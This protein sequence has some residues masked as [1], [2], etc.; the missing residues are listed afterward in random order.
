VVATYR[1]LILSFFLGCNRRS[2]STLPAAEAP[3][4][5][6]TPA[7]VATVAV[8]TPVALPPN[9]F[10]PNDGVPRIYAK[11]RYVWV[12][13]K[14]EARSG[15]TGFLWVG[16]W[17]VLR[18]PKPVR[19]DGACP[20]GWYAVE[21]WGYVCDDGVTATTNRDDPV[22]QGI[23]AYAPHVDRPAP[24]NYGESREAPRYPRLPTWEEQE[25]RE[26]TLESHLAEVAAV[27][28]GKAPKP[29][30]VDVDLTPASGE[31]FSLPVLPA[32]LQEDR[33]ELRRLSTVAW[34]TEINHDYRTYLLSADYKYVP[35]DRVAPYAESSFA[36]VHLEGDKT[37]PIAFFRGKARSKYRRDA[38][39]SF[40]PTDEMWSRLSWVK[41][42]GTSERNGDETYLE[43][44]DAGFYTTVRDAVVPTPQ[45]QTPWGAPTNEPDTTG[46]A[47]SGRATW[48]EASIL[49]GWM[50]AYEGTTPVWVTLISPGRGGMPVKGKPLLSTASTPTGVLPLTGKFATATMVGPHEFIHSDVPWAQNFQGPYAIHGAYWHDRWGEKM[51]GG[52]INVS[53]IDGYWLFHWTEP[54]IPA[55]WHGVRLEPSE[56]PPTLLVI[57][58]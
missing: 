44:T 47:P 7:P 37:L 9:A 20:G 2:P 3:S 34:T 54:H 16:G 26:H 12:N 11:S 19:G 49:G 42:T 40:A 36:G 8:D 25:W 52:C 56:G 41:L 30:L 50:I 22:L 18:E 48:L 4:D 45:E 31:P 46:K 23:I 1:W 39:G 6:P 21:P 53:L 43:T 57:H 10:L 35:K 28:S 14:P 15:W 33:R 55:G 29:F 5:E 24:H 27:R 13:Y 17:A 58:S 51:S 32:R 38:N